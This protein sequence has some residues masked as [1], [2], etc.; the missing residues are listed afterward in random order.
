MGLVA[1]GFSKLMDRELRQS[2]DRELSSQAYFAALAGLNDARAYLANGG[3]ALNGCSDWKTNALAQQYFTDNLDGSGN[4]KYTCVSIAT[5]PNELIYTLKTDQSVTFSVSKPNMAR[6]YFGWENNPKPASFVALGSTGTLPQESKPPLPSNATG[7]LEVGMY[8][9][10]AGFSGSAD[11][12]AS[13]TSFA[14][15]YYMYP[16]SGGGA[17]GSVDYSSNGNFVPGNCKTSNSNPVN[18]STAAPRMCNTYISGLQGGGGTNT[19]YV[20]LTARYAPI[21]VT[22]QAA[23][24]GGNSL[25]A[26]GNGQA[27]IDVTGQGTDV[28]QRIRARIDISKNFQAPSYAIQSMVALCKGFRMNIDSLGQYGDPSIDPGIPNSDGACAVPSSGG[29]VGGSAGDLGPH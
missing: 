24:N 2:L 22:I 5:N 15:T 3:G 14:R 25:S 21:V 6:M 19:Y 12:N 10:P 28:L 4:A 8:P 1:V 18:G 16:N 17:P 23:N 9:I 20:R 29:P 11:T 26:I 27:V 7:L 13:L